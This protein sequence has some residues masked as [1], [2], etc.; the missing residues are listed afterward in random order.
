MSARPKS[1][2]DVIDV[3]RGYEA[4]PTAEPQLEPATEPPVAED[5]VELATLA[6]VRASQAPRL[7]EPLAA[8]EQR[9]A[10]SLAEQLF[11]T[12]APA[13]GAL[14]RDAGRDPA[15]VT[16]ALQAY[17]R[18][19]AYAGPRHAPRATVVDFCR[20]AN[21]RYLAEVTARPGRGGNWSAPP[22]TFTA[23]MGPGGFQEALTWMRQLTLGLRDAPDVK[24]QRL[25]V[26]VDESC[27]PDGVGAKAREW[28]E[29]MAVEA[30]CV[31]AVLQDQPGSAAVWKS[32]QV[33]QAA[34]PASEPVVASE[35][36]RS[37]LEVEGIPVKWLESAAF[38]VQLQGYPERIVGPA[39]ETIN[40]TWGQVDSEGREYIG[41]RGHREDDRGQLRQFEVV[42]GRGLLVS[43]PDVRVYLQV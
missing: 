8:P 9:R 18:T 33:K 29:Q 40:V 3:M 2:N 5:L 17:A 25:L 12:K 28:L 31:V 15:A 16:G 39:G 23:P 4:P 11:A 42:I 27:F 24:D 36:M 21:G 1:V 10:P 22:E 34:K 26:V 41:L 14:V 38:R 37:A 7:G 20:D 32:K 43:L 19:G 35:P 6:R 13:V 30:N